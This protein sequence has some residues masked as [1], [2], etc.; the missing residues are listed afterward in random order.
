MDPK[1]FRLHLVR[2]AL[3]IVDLWSEGAE[4]LLLG[5]AAQESHFK[6]VRQLNDGPALGFFQMEPATHNDIWANYLEYR[7]ELACKILDACGLSDDPPVADRL[8]W[9][10]RYA[11]IMARIHYLRVPQKLPSKDD[12]W[13][14]GKYW[15]AYY[16]TPKGK[17]TVEEYVHNYGRVK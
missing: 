16:N 14:Q 9:D 10:A 11:A 4:E 15:K 7:H 6:Y 5:T 3:Q 12:V 17:G 1:Q 13:G 8:V 2:P